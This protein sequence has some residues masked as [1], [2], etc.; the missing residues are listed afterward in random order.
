[1]A[2]CAGGFSQWIGPIDY[3]LDLALF[4]QGL[5]GDQV[6]QVLEFDRWTGLLAYEEWRQVRLDEVA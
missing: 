5:Q 2:D 1:M 6:R 4:D 3:R